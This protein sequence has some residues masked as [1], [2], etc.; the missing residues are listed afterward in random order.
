MSDATVLINIVL[1]NP[2]RDKVLELIRICSKYQSAK[3]LLFDN[4]SNS[5]CLEN[6]NSDHI[7]L[8]NSPRNVGVAGAHHYACKMAERENSDFVLFLDQDTQ[9]PEE[10]IHNIISEFYQLQKLHAR[11]IAVGPTWIDPRTY[12]WYQERRERI[13][14]RN[15]LRNL[16]KITE[17]KKKIHNLL[18]LDNIIISSG[19]LIR[20]DAFKEIGYPEKHYFID[21]VDI[22]WC[23]RALSK[24][25]HI[26]MLKNI[27]IRHT[28]G[29]VKKNKNSVL[30]YQKPLRYYYSIRNSF[31]LFGEKQ[32]PFNF[33]IF[34]L[35]R[36]ILE[37]KKIPFVPESKKSLIAAL[38]GL[39]DGFLSR[40]GVYL[41]TFK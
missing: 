13:S 16:L 1:Y 33:R 20:V 3:I 30:H 5:E 10:F 38:H 2:D 22:E 6:I 15:S 29:E 40:K 21:L 41:E 18:R 8:F 36:N 28:I 12:N 31:L 27:K 9:L 14:L 35:I 24:N 17:K 25:Y 7:I 26:E 34:I 19:M 23:L 11:L 4:A 37:I 39:K 32:Y